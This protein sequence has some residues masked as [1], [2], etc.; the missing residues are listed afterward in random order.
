MRQ[1][2]N[3]YAVK[4]VAG[5]D[6]GREVLGWWRGIGVL[7]PN[8]AWLLMIGLAALALS[9]ST[10]TRNLSEYEE[11]T[12]RRSRTAGEVESV[13]QVNESI[14]RQTEELRRDPEAGRHAAKQ[15][16]RLVDRNEVVIAVR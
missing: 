12:A 2:V 5:A 14:R 3:S 8:L 4:S 16:L 1:V 11:A 13:R 9:L 15:R 10:L 6:Y 7:V